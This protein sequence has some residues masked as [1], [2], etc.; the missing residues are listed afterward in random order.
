MLEERTMDDQ[1]AAH[2]AHHKKSSTEGVPGRLLIVVPPRLPS[3]IDYFAGMLA[4]SGIDVIVDRRNAVRRRKSGALPDDRRRRDRRGHG[5][6]FGYLYGCS[7]VRVRRV[8]A[9]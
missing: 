2:Q 3:R 5:H 1:R 6:L 9:N 7:I 4:G 8:T